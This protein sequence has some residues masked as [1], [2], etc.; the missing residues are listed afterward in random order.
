M[1]RCRP[2]R[3]WLKKGTAVGVAAA[4]SL[5]SLLAACAHPQRFVPIGTDPWVALD[6]KTGRTCDTRPPVPGRTLSTLP[7]CYD[8]YKA[9]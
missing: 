8:L 5:V 4:L 1:F 7:F 9:D 2:Y 6:T 3:V